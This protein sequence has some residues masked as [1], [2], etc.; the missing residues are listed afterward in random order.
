MPLS[1]SQLLA[2]A[3][4]VF[5]ETQLG[6]NSA[7][8]VGG[9]LIQIVKALTLPYSPQSEYQAGQYVLFNDGL[10]RSLQTALV[11]ES[12]TAA[13]AKW[14]LQSSRETLV[15]IAGRTP[16]TEA[17][18]ADYLATYEKSGT[19]PGKV[20]IKGLSIVSLWIKL[21]ISLN[22]EIR[23]ALVSQLALTLGDLVDLVTSKNIVLWSNANNLIRRSSAGVDASMY[24]QWIDSAGAVF[25]K[26]QTGVLGDGSAGMVDDA[27]RFLGFVGEDV[28][29]NRVKRL[30]AESADAQVRT[31]DMTL[32]PLADRQSPFAVLQS[33]NVSGRI[34]LRQATDEQLQSKI[35]ALLQPTLSAIQEGGKRKKGVVT[36]ICYYTENIPPVDV[37]DFDIVPATEAGD[38]A[39]SDLT[40]NLQVTGNLIWAE[41]R[42][43][44]SGQPADYAYVTYSGNFTFRVNIDNPDLA[45]EARLHVRLTKRNVVTAS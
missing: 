37:Q 7:E 11:G 12:P 10:F 23:N 17:T 20:E 44:I 18:T 42:S 30:K 33:N 26:L 35:L 27:G 41:V 39:N 14:K 29:L 45:A 28:A 1:F 25:N 3:T 16:F 43:A 19:S 31:L 40:H 22:P 34:E 9:L 4:E 13:P 24:Y 36:A 38:H 32:A 2:D 8:R 21:I 15:E 5:D 6:A